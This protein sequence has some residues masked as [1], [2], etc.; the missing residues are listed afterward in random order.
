MSSLRDPSVFARLESSLASLDG[1]IGKAGWFPGSVYES[2]EPVA[3][4]AAV[5][6]FGATISHPGGTPYKIGA[7]GKA[8]FVSKANG[9]GLPVT[10]SHTIVIPPR[11]F[12]RP[13]VDR[14]QQKW[15][16][17]L[18]S[19]AR[20]VLAGKTDAKSVMEA[21]VLNA[22]AEIARSISQVF[23]PP[24]KASTIAKR[25]NALT[26]KKTVG[27]LTKPLVDSGKMISDVQ[28]IVEKES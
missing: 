14:M 21:V 11:P 26:D 22:A 6:E 5:Q 12:M 8:V 4:I 27:S 9:A 20:S 10:K 19:G 13:T 16:D 23:T 24:L 3:Y 17:M 7:D 28:G 1:L 18:A 2:G 15:T 25:R